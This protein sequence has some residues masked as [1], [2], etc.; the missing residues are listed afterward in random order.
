MFSAKS[1]EA[2]RVLRATP[3]PHEAS[4]DPEQPRPVAKAKKGRAW[5]SPTSACEAADSPLL[6]THFRRSKGVCS[7][8]ATRLF[9]KTG[10]LLEVFNKEEES[11]WPNSP[12]VQAVI[13]GLKKVPAASARPIDQAKH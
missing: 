9:G 2:E 6:A 1:G 3:V 10:N 5:L 11:H 7:D 13:S 4:H 8:L 12:W